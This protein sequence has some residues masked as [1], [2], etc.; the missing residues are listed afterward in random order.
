MPTTTVQP[1][2]TA[3][4]P[5]K[6]DPKVVIYFDANGNLA[7]DAYENN[8]EKRADRVA[9]VWRGAKEKLLF[10]N[11]TNRRICIAFDKT[12]FEDAGWGPINPNATQNVGAA[13]DDAPVEVPLK[14]TVF[15]P[16]KDKLDPNV[17]VMN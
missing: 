15:A 1:E 11:D 16:G 10:R 12:P 14:Y 4:T 3:G 8:G 17:I 9:Y 6:V 5:V 7:V 2:G 13:R